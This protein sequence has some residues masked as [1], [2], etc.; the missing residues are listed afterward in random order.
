MVLLVV[1]VP[2]FSMIFSPPAYTPCPA[3]ECPV[4]PEYPEI[5][6][7][8][9]VFC[10]YIPEEIV[11]FICYL[12]LEK[13][14]HYKYVVI[15]PFSADKVLWAEVYNWDTLDHWRLRRKPLNQTHSY[16]EVYESVG[17]ELWY[18]VT[19]QVSWYEIYRGQYIVVYV[20]REDV[21]VTRLNL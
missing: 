12:D 3:S 9:G 8:F 5:V 10:D 20:V 15:L 16:I 17:Y 7:K 13:Y 2:A 1:F 6:G 14:D 19:R 4:C 18:Y 21:D 11:I